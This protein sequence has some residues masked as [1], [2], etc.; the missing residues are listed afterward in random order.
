M[1][2]RMEPLR[3]LNAT[4]KTS[5]AE[6][7]KAVLQVVE[8][9]ELPLGASTLVL[10][11]SIRFSNEFVTPHSCNEPEFE[12]AHKKV[13]AD[14]EVIEELARRYA[15]RI[16]SAS[17]GWKNLALSENHAVE[18]SFSKAGDKV[19]LRFENF[20]L[21]GANVFDFANAAYVEHTANLELLA[22]AIAKGLLSSEHTTLE[23]SA[24]FEMGEGTRAF[25][26]QEWQ[27]ETQQ[28][29]S[30]EEWGGKK[31]S[32]VTRVYAKIPSRN[33]APVPIINDRKVGNALRTIDT[34][35]A[36]GQES[37]PIAVEIYGAN[38]H[39]GESFR[40]ANGFFSVQKKVAR[41]DALSFDE[42]AYYIALC[43]RGGVLGGEDA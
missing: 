1:A 31:S 8:S 37:D 18:V 35:Y 14:K 13:V 5:E 40:S 32:G 21:A 29:K 17:F 23:V 41:G 30:K 43:I 20:L 22:D 19:S 26:S 34:W 4:S 10:K 9:T 25:P 28:S 12:A 11:G 36:L 15:I 3:G 16:A 2:L 33:G 6:K 42:K 38:A 39:K 7:V 27:S 24:Y